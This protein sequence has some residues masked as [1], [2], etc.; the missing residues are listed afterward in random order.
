MDIKSLLKHL[1]SALAYI[2][3][4]IVAKGHN[5]SRYI[6]SFNRE[7]DGKWYI[8]IPSWKGAHSALQMVAGADDMLDLIGNGAPYVKLQVIKSNKEID[9]IEAEMLCD[10]MEHSMTGGATYRVFNKEGIDEMWLCPV[11]LFVL[12]EYPKHIYISKIE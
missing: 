10:R 9:S 4:V 6:L 2:K 3:G 8:D 12:G 5:G 1:P 11:T 7:E